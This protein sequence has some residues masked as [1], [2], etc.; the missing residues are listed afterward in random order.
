MT[1]DSHPDA[2][3]ALTRRE[4]TLQ[5]ALAI[6]SGVV[7]TVSGCG[8][9]ST[10]T[11]PTPTPAATDVTG[12]IANNHNHVAVILAARQTQGSAFA[13]DIQGTASHPHTVDLTQADLTSLVN[14]Q[15]VSKTSSTNNGHSHAVTF[16]VV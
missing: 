3:A 9:K 15:V 4:F 14:R 6:L 8:G 16:T 13:L 12:T 2:P 5:S 11:T 10:P 1:Q 7:I